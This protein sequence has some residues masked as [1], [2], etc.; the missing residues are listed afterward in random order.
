MCAYWDARFGSEGKIWGDRPS[1]TAEYASA[2]FRKHGVRDVLVPGAGYGRNAVLFSRSGFAVTGVE[3]SQAAVKIAMASG[4]GVKYLQGSFLDV[5]VAPGS[6]DAVYCFNVLHLFKEADRRRFV[7]K[8]A[9][10]LRDGGLAFFAVFSD[11]E[12]SYGKG[13]STEANTFESKPGRPVHYFTDEDLRDHFAGFDVLESGL[14]EDPE[15]HGDEGP[16]VH[17]EHYILASVQKH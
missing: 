13:T 14:M 12:A 7:A 17:M 1:R 2:A 10:A 4:D 16:H 15:D 11:T 5:S 8:C 9:D 3:I 6:F